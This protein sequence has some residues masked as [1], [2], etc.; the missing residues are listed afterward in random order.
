MRVLIIHVILYSTML[1]QHLPGDLQ[2][3]EAIFGQHTNV[4]TNVW[5]DKK[6]VYVIATK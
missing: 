1:S 4:V 5:R 2:R 6:L 3:G